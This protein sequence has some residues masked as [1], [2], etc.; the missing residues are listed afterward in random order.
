MGPAQIRRS[1]VVGDRLYTVCEVGVEATDLSK[2]EDR[3]WGPVRLTRRQRAYTR[4][5]WYDISQ[6][7]TEPVVSFT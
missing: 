1:V 5:P 7:T 2:F 4:T 6:S 3:A